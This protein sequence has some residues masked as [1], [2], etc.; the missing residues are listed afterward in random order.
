MRFKKRILRNSHANNY[1][2]LNKTP[3]IL[4]HGMAVLLIHLERRDL[5]AMYFLLKKLLHEGK[6]TETL[7]VEEERQKKG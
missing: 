6:L 1:K 3:L 5:D 4:L 2:V 7:V